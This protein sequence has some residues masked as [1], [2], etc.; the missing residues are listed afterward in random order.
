MEIPATIWTFFGIT[1]F[2]DI[3]TLFLYILLKPIEKKQKPEIKPKELS[4]LIPAHLE[5]RKDIRRTIKAVY[6]ED[7]DFNKVIL[8]GDADSQGMQELVDNLSFRYPNLTYVESPERSKAKKIN[9]VA[10]K[11]PDI[12]KYLYVRDCRV[13]GERDCISKMLSH[14]T[15]DRVAAVTSY[16]TVTAPRNFLARSYH[17]GKDWV[18]SIGA[19]RKI[20]QEKRRGVF[21]VCGAS[22]IYRVDILKKIPMPSVTKTEDTHYTWTL[23]MHGYKVNVAHEA[24]VTAPD[25]DGS[26]LNGIRNQVKQTYRWNTGTVQCIYAE[27]S[28]LNKSKAL[29]YTTIVPGFFEALTYSMAVIMIPVLFYFARNFAIGFLIG[30]AVFSLAATLIFLPKDFIKTIFHYPQIMFYKYLS[31]IIFITA[32]LMVSMQV[33]TGR[34]K[35]WTNEWRPLK[36]A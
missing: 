23:Q 15:S 7:Y 10:Q 14:F 5:S 17:Y 2:I 6:Q 31:A 11:I 35:R 33:L 8:C 16:G 34:S 9:Y 36:T 19:F 22:T 28:K 18:N 29:L 3:I 20:A 30:D 32:V 24:T 21:V 13:I 27:R 1:L 25:V 12:G 4:V 26:W